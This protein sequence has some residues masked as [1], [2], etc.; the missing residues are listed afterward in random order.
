MADLKQAKLRPKWST[1]ISK[2]AGNL[3]AKPVGVGAASQRLIPTGERS[4]LQTRIAATVGTKTMSLFQWC[5][6]TYTKIQAIPD[7]QK[8]RQIASMTVKKL[9]LIT[10]S[11]V[12]TYLRHG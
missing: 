12:S 10:S 7:R 11:D 2:A 1:T 9:L 3:S 4:G 8:A 5:K 6:A